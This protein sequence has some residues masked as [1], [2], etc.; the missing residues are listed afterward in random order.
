[1]S[2]VKKTY[3]LKS[4][5]IKALENSGDEIDQDEAQEQFHPSIGQDSR[6]SRIKNFLGMDQKKDKI[7]KKKSG[8]L[9][10]GKVNPVKLRSIEESHISGF[11][12]S[13]NCEEEIYVEGKMNFVKQATNKS[14]LTVKPMVKKGA[15]AS[16]GEKGPERKLQLRKSVE[17]QKV[18]LKQQAYSSL[19]QVFKE[20][21]M[22]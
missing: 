1:M 7:D 15:M 20:S 11:D 2:R 19:L 17:E 16:L 21:H 8:K 13:S 18:M 5:G 3:K 4:E 14:N 9:P 12:Q 22:G 6:R 10:A